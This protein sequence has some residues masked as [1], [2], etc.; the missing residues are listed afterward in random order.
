[1]LFNGR[2]FDFFVLLTVADAYIAEMNNT[3]IVRKL[4][5]IS[6]GGMERNQEQQDN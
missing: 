2:G 6:K 4:I 5:D 3:L 1:M